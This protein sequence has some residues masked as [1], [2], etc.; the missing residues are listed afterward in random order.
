[1]AN[2]SD[3]FSAKLPRQYKRILAME[4]AY[5]YIKNNQERGVIKKAYIDAHSNF[6]A[7]K[8]RRNLSEG[9]ESATENS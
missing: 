3:C 5:G 8:L 7:F 1:M 6:V 4:E 2:R 9:S